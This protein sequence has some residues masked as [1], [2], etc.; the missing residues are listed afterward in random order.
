V[1]E[2]C[3]DRRMMPR[4]LRALASLIVGI[5]AVIG[6]MVYQ[7]YSREPPTDVFAVAVATAATILTWVMTGLE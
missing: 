1:I 6:M 5:T 2:P 7:L 3:Y 4:P